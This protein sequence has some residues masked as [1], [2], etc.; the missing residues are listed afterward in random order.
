MLLIAIYMLELWPYIQDINIKMN[1]ILLAQL[2]KAINAYLHSDPRSKQKLLALEHKVLNLCLLPTSMVLHCVFTKEEIIVQMNAQLAADTTISATPLQLLRLLLD[3]HNPQRF[4]SQEI[5]IQGDTELGQKA[6]ALLE[7]IE[8]D[9]EDYLSRFIGDVPV[10]YL[11]R[12]LEQVKTSI[13]TVHHKFT[14]DLS[15]FVQEEAAWLPSKQ[16]LEDFFKDVDQLRMAVD[17]AEAKC[18]AAQIQKDKL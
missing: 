1:A 6:L 12:F 14:N 3:K 4:F 2:N 15:E 8:I 10:Y 16:A 11:G 13:A 5:H 9:W 7:E 18:Q 17:R